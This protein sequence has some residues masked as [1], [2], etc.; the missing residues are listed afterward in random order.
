MGAEPD[1]DLQRAYAEAWQ[2]YARL[3]LDGLRRQFEDKLGITEVRGE[4]FEAGYRKAIAD[5]RDEDLYVDWTSGRGDVPYSPTARA[6][7][8]PAAPT[9]DVVRVRDSRGL[10]WKRSVV[11]GVYHGDTW[12]CGELTRFSFVDLLAQFGPLTEEGES[13]A[14]A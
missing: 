14:Q 8:M 4:S 2:P 10:T 6:W 3:N 13:D 7:R 12:S 1:P 11:P 5:L 9:A